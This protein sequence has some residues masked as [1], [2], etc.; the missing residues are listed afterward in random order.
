MYNYRFLC[1]TEFY[2][3]QILYMYMV[4][5]DKSFNLVNYIKYSLSIIINVFLF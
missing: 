3:E 2:Y 5:V 4:G 1:I